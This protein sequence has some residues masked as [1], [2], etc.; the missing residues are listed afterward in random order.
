MQRLLDAATSKLEVSVLALHAAAA[1]N[2]PVQQ[3]TARTWLCAP[4]ASPPQEKPQGAVPE[5]WLAA[6]AGSGVATSDMAADL[7]SLLAAKDEEEAK[8]VRK[9]AYLASNALLKFTVPQLEGEGGQAVDLCLVFCCCF[10]PCACA[11]WF[12]D[13]LFCCFICCVVGLAVGAPSP[14]V[15]QPGS[16]AWRGPGAGSMGCVCVCVREICGEGC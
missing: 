13:V 7:A 15:G 16:G 14:R 9:A 5:A 6:L 4:C 11:T 8:N 12:C 1:G 10:E 3:P 2:C